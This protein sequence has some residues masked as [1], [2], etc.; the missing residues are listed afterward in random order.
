MAEPTIYELSSP[1]RIG[2]HFP[3]SDVPETRI[4]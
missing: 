3:E 4:A 2:I 1:G